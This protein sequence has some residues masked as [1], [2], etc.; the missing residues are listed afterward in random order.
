MT[1]WIR[2]LASARAEWLPLVVNCL[3]ALRYCVLQRPLE[4]GKIC[5]WIGATLLTVGLLLMKG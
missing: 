3:L 1:A 2:G 5:Y 4:P